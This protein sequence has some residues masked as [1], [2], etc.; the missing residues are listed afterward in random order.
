MGVAADALVAL[1]QACFLIVQ[2]VPAAAELARV[3][4]AR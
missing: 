3:W 2:A 1:E 4:L